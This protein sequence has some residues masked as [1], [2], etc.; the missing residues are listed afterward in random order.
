MDECEQ[1]KLQKE[2]EEEEEEQSDTDEEDERNF[3]PP[4]D[5]RLLVNGLQFEKYKKIYESR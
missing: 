4:A 5:R 1:E 3:A 2:V